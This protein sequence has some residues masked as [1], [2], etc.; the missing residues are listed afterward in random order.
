M[1]VDLPR[2]AS[3]ARTVFDIG[4]YDGADTAYYLECGFRVVALE[5]NPELIA[6]AQRR[7]KMEIASGKLVCV[8]AAVTEDGRPTEL[9]LSAD[10]LGSSSIFADLVATKRPSGSVTV[11]GTTIQMLFAEH[12]LPYYL[13]VD[14]EGADRFCVLALSEQERPRYLSFEIRDDFEELLR[15]AH[16]IGFFRY[17]II[18]QTNFRELARQRLLSDRLRLR[19]LRLLGYW[20]PEL[21]RRRGRFF[22]CGHSS[23]PAPWHSDGK[24]HSV[25]ATMK[26]WQ[27]TKAT[28]VGASSW[29]DLHAV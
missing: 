19:M 2:N 3:S 26:R 7:F 10:D 16:S 17:K 21:V 20:N 28:S 13:K 14:I 9:V 24:W 27:A 29:Y 11:P 18:S 12:G 15:H 22:A 6:R 23:G 5:A 8:N 4:M 1:F 25:E